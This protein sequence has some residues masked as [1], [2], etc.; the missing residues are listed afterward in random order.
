[1]IDSSSSSERGE[2]EEAITAEGKPKIDLAYLRAFRAF[3][4]ASASNDAFVSRNPRFDAIQAHRICSHL[5]DDSSPQADPA[6]CVKRSQSN[7]TVRPA[8]DS[9]ARLREAGEEIMTGLWALMAGRWLNFGKIVISPAHELLMAARTTTATTTTK[10]Q[11]RRGASA[12][13]TSA[14]TA[15]HQAVD[16]TSER[17][18]VLDL[19][20]IP[21]G[22]ISNIIYAFIFLLIFFL[23]M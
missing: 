13:Q 11:P 16:T 17:R 20:G 19:G 23:F 12:S 3:V 4:K 7:A 14:K 1:M 6:V 10:P 5:R 2:D 21:V 18:R 9:K 8:V 22:T 15:I